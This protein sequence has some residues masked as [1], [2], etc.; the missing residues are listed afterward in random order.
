MERVLILDATFVGPEGHNL[1]SLKNFKHNLENLGNDVT[2]GHNG[3]NPYWTMPSLYRRFLDST[4]TLEKKRLVFFIFKKLMRLNKFKFIDHFTNELWIFVCFLRLDLSYKKNNIEFLNYDHIFIPHSDTIMAW[5]VLRKLEKL[6]KKNLATPRVSLRFICVFEHFKLGKNAS[7]LSKFVESEL[8]KGSHVAIYSETERYIVEL[9][10]IFTKSCQV[11]FTPP[12]LDCDKSRALNQD[13]SIFIVG[14]FRDDK[15]VRYLPQLIQVAA[16]NNFQ[17]KIQTNK[18]FLAEVS[19][20]FDFFGFNEEV[21][22]MLPT[23][24]SRDELCEAILSSLAI[25]SLHNRENFVFRGS[26]S[27]FEAADH[28]LPLITWGGSA[29]AFTVQKYG[30][31]YVIEHLADLPETLSIIESEIPRIKQNIDTFNRLRLAKIKEIF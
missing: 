22:T 7:P 25:V 10:K 13:K 12:H 29:N 15:G 27:L 31:G 30:I 23:Y 17:V 5:W 1:D 2:V 19:T 11:F 20:K 4:L 6:Q 3:E 21:I 26:A 18:E 14:K 16:T 8:I 9:E 24:L 28:G